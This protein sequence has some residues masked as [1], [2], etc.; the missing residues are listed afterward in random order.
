MLIESFPR[1]KGNI[2]EFYYIFY[3]FEGKNVNDTLGFVLSKF[4]QNK[5][6][7]PLGFVTTDYA[8]ALWVDKKISLLHKILNQ[9]EIKK[10]L[11][12]WLHE[13]SL[14]K[15]NFRKVATI[16]GLIDKG[17]PNA[18][19][20]ISFNSDL[21]FEVL[22]KYEKDHV[23]IKAAKDESK[24]DLV[25]IDRL[26]IYLEKVKNKIIYK[27]LEKISP[28][29]VPLMIEINKEF[30]NKKLIDEYY[31]DRLENELLKEVGL[32]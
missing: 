27:N 30:V 12:E 21:I 22:M 13:S 2:N 15:R 16:S 26:Y 17:F 1:K 8:L 9:D 3:T 24:R 11:N 20:K 18:R 7:K 23:L 14:F 31:L 4:F 32:N 25:E 5:G 29:S 10:S 19:K 28:F 6:Y